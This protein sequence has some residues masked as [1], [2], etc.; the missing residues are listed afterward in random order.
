M[1]IEDH[2]EIAELKVPAGV[3]IDVISDEGMY[4]TGEGNG[5]AYDFLYDP[6]TRHWDTI[7]T[8]ADGTMVDVGAD[9]STTVI[10][11]ED[12]TGDGTT[13]TD[14]ETPSDYDMPPPPA[15]VAGFFSPLSIDMGSFAPPDHL[16]ISA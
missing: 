15:F 4:V 16:V 2:P 11:A 10:P 13:V 14:N 12:G 3:T 8:G 1:L 6:D 5:G 7:F 9:G